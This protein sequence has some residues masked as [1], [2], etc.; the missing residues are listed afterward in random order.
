M[1]VRKKHPSKLKSLSNKDIKGIRKDMSSL[2]SAG[3]SGIGSSNEELAKY[4]RGRAGIAKR[5]TNVRRPTAKTR[6]TDQAM[7]K[8][9]RILKKARNR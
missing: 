9:G 6:K 1:A 8:A 4:N 2:K 5:G 7:K 3:V